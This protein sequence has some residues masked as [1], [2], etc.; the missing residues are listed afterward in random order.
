MAMCIDS[1][2]SG[3]CPLGGLSYIY[4]LFL[5]KRNCF[6]MTLQVGNQAANLCQLMVLLDGK[7]TT[8]CSEQLTVVLTTEC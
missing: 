4:P 7:L 5:S 2:M 1:H 3:G 8:G 6:C